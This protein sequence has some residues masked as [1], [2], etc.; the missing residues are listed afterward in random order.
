M[1]QPGQPVCGARRGPGARGGAASRAGGEPEPHSAAASDRGDDHFAD[2]RRCWAMG[3]HR[4]AAG[5]E[6]LAAAIQIPDPRA[7]ARGRKS[8]WNG[9]GA[10]TGERNP[11]RTGSGAAGA[12][13]GSIPD[14]QSGADRR[15]RPPDRG[16]RPAAGCTGS[17]MCAAGD[18]FDSGG[19]GTGA[20]AARQCRFR[21][22][23]CDAGKYGSGDGR[24]PGQT[25]Y[26]R[27]KGA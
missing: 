2:R 15:G 10:G 16:A 21:A 27:C 22:A 12:Q 13:D 8:V 3:Q 20:L 26:P 11:L 25:P 23:Q 24:V 5:F 19:A 9:T 4:A 17:G 6:R 14:H 1:R 7:D 18:F